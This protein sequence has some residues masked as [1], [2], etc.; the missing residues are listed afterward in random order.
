MSFNSKSKKFIAL[1]ALAMTLISSGCATSNPLNKS[2][3]VE[4]DQGFFSYPYKQDGE[5]VKLSDLVENL[6]QMKVDEKA[7]AGFHRWRFC[8]IAANWVS[9][10][11]SAAG[12]GLASAN[13]IDMTYAFLGVSVTSLLVS[14]VFGIQA[15]SNLIDATR[16]YNKK[17]QAVPAN[18]TLLDNKGQGGFAPSIAV[19]PFLTM[20]HDGWNPAESRWAPQLGAAI[21]Y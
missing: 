13:K 18:Q 19:N 20:A 11:A 4:I 15:R 8:S 5:R 14:G 3:P 7:M 1:I 6:D 12:I 16:S 17:F 2:K 9:I 21:S 10:A